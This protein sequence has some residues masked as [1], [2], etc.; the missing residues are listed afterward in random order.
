[1]HIGVLL[2][3]AG[4]DHAEAGAV[5]VPVD[6]VG[7]VGSG[8]GVGDDGDVISGDRGEV[9][10]VDGHIAGLRGVAGTDRVPRPVVD[11]PDI[12]AG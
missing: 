1:M 12:E 2:V 9:E 10:P 4:F 3:G 5:A 7:R 8:C 11:P 6:D